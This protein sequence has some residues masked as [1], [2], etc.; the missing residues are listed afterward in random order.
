MTRWW[1]ALVALVMLAAA[2]GGGS[3]PS[4]GAES[5]PS[6]T[7]PTSTTPAASSTTA[8]PPTSAPLPDR[9]PT[10]DQLTAGTEPLNIAHAGGDQAFPHS[11]PYA[12]A[13]AVEAGVDVLEMDVQLTA[14]G[15]LIVQHDDTVDRRTE[16]TGRVDSYTFD[17]INALDGAYWF[18]P[19]QWPR[20]DLDESAYVFR[21]VRT[22]DTPAPDGFE[23]DDFAIAS[24]RDIAERFPTM[25]FDIEIKGSFAETPDVV[26]V[27]AEE[28]RATDRLDSTVVTSFDDEL[29]DEFSQ[30]A[31]E[32]AT[33]P[34]LAELT[35]WVLAGEPLNPRHPIV[36]IPPEFQ[37]Q[38]VLTPELLV[39]AEEAGV[40]VWIWPSDAA[41]QENAGFYQELLDMGIEGIIAGDPVALAGIL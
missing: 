35:S 5:S 17:E 9:P 37:G 28:L 21:G 2:C 41:T 32:V 1:I 4:E 33:S 34:G 7:A 20:R 23:A 30:L 31:P 14:D 19:G 27:L 18:A 40:A 29:I 8:A 10:I 11:T 13:Q 6:T 15:V 36:Q 12:F 38:Q 22:G 16:T 24:F 26:A 25:P 3:E 39:L